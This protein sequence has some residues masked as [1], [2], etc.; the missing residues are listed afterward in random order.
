MLSATK[1][2]FCESTGRAAKSFPKVFF[3]LKAFRK[4]IA[5]KK[6]SLIEAEKREIARIYAKPAPEGWSI[7]SFLE[8]AKIA[9]ISGLTSADEIANFHQEVASCFDDWNDFI[10]SDKKDLMRVSNLLSGAQVK[11]LAHCIELFNHGLFDL[12]TT[13]QMPVELMGK[14][15]ARQDEPWTSQEDKTLI[16][17]AVRKYDYTFGDVWV[18]VS[19]EMMRTPDE[20]QTRF[21]EIYI[22]HRNKA[23]STEVVLSK[24]FRPL[25]M[26][27]Q[28][29]VIPP[30]CYIVP[31]DYNFPSSLQ[32]FNLPEAF[33][34]YRH[35]DSF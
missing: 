9:Q 10:S 33:Q 23:K 27:R 22:K 11:K 32:T 31:S 4:G 24:S 26:N 20:V 15:P 30:Q 35:S 18:Y 17:L 21:V 29:R 25:L 16:D 19:S 12:D 34:K 2:L 5:E 1:A 14:R 6:K 28:F 8:K 3:D 13:K 7:A